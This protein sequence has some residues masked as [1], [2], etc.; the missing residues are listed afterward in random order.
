MVRVIQDKDRDVNLELLWTI[1]TVSFP[2]FLAYLSC[3]VSHVLSIP[4]LSPS[5]MLL[6]DAQISAMSNLTPF[7]LSKHQILN[8]TTQCCPT[9]YEISDPLLLA[10]T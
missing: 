10:W 8:Y 3:S 6:L 9:Y 1:C 5:L 4:Q 7:S 2:P